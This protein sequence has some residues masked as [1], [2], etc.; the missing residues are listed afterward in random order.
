V[1]YAFHLPVNAW[2]LAV[3]VPV[4]FLLQMLPVSVNGFGIR[5][6]T[7]SFYLTRFGVPFELAVLLPLS[8]Q[9]LIMVFSLTGAAVYVARRSHVQPVPPGL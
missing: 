7:F 9:V 6:A 3:V 5:E 1:V 2:D 4:S 8:A